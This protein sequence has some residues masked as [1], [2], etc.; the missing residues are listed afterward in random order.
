MKGLLAIFLTVF[1]LLVLATSDS[2]CEAPGRHSRSS[3][4][5]VAG[6]LVYFRDAR[7][8]LCFAF[9]QP[10]KS[11]A[12]GLLTWVPCQAVPAALFVR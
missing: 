4:G 5:D 2:S 3:A 6:S 8:G 12:S 10:D 9:A 7:T 11:S 1:L